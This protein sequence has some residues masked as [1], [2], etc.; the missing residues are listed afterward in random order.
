MSNV[1]WLSDTQ[2]AKLERFFPKSRGKPRVDDRRVMSG[3]ISIN[4]NGLQWHDALAE[5][6]QQKTLHRR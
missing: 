6:G 3:I 2:M 4:R 1:C 5:C